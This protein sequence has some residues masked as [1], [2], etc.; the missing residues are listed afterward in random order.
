MVARARELLSNNDPTGAN[1]LIDSY[2]QAHPHPQPPPPRGLHLARGIAYL[3]RNVAF[4]ALHGFEAEMYLYP[5]N[6]EARERFNDL[7]AQMYPTGS[8]QPQQ[9]K[10]ETSLSQE[11]IRN[12]ESNSQRYTYRGVP[13]IKN[14]FDMAIYPMLL[15]QIK[16]A[17]IIEVGT[18]YGGSA[19]WLSDLTGGFGLDT[20]IYS[21]DVQGMPLLQPPRVTFMKGDG[22]ALERSL[23]PQFI[24]ELP[25]PLLVIEDADHSQ[26]TTTAVL[27]FFHPILRSGE[28]IVVED[29][30]S[31][32]GPVQALQM[33]FAAH[34]N[35]YE[36]DA[37]CCDF[38]GTN[39]TWCVNGFL[40]K[41]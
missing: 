36:V 23:S 32:P 33:F 16:P 17:T 13:M 6:L 4:L 39:V 34:G 15:W 5:D 40:R 29:G 31:A 35:E 9:R 20:H 12:F 14:C 38:F 3:Q 7:R 25:R 18:F 28:Y 11:T 19:A 37:R 30:L 26:L 8:S 1:Q 21:I 24:A 22:R 27:N 10:W 2:L 41:R